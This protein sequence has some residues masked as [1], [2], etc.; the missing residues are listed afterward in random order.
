[1]KNFPPFTSSNLT[2][3]LRIVALLALGCISV[4]AKT[5]VVTSSI[6]KALSEAADGD[7]VLVEGPQSFKEHVVVTNGVHLVGANSPVIDGGGQGTTLVLSAPHATASGLV[8]R[9]SGHDLTRVDSGVL[10]NAD[11]VSV[12][13][14]RVETD[15]FGIYLRGANNCSINQNVVLGGTSLAP[16]ARGNGVHLW[17]AQR[18]LI[19]NNIV[20]EKRDGMYFSYADYNI[21]AGNQVSDTR[22]GIHYMYSHQN[23]LLTNALSRNAV[24]ATLMF[25]RQA[26]VQGNIVTANRRHGMVL[27]QFDS[28]RVI[29]NVVCGQNRGFFV[30]QANQN[31]FEGNLIATNDIG[32]YLSNISEDNVF[33]GNAFIRNT[34]QVW[35]P[36]FESGQGRKGP[37]AFHEHGRGNYWSDYTGTDRNHDGIGD[38][39]YHE[40]DA[41]GYIVDRHPA[42]RIFAMSPA[43][44]LL[45]K[46]EELMPVLDTE[47]VT[48]LAPL[49]TS[50]WSSSNPLL[51]ATH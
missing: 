47:G 15:G 27:K 30:Q 13:N 22:F 42:A 9:N 5:I 46:G 28:S 34:D 1:L 45:R 12:K 29:G 10:I 4:E 41:F 49:M 51:F 38:T 36:P 3:S 18:N 16:S 2:N 33:T 48:D 26:L 31:R 21:I 8:I 19:I 17:K 7:T 43:V 44:A 35:Q 39:P 20:R 32:L 14:C 50:P 24:G 11:N 25:S 6:A 23:Q 40:T 37:N